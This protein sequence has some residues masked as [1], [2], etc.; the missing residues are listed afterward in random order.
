MIGELVDMD[1]VNTPTYD[2]ANAIAISCRM[3]ARMNGRKEILVPK[4][5]S[6]ARLAVVENYC[7]PEIK[8]VQ[9]AFDPKT[10]LLDLADLRKDF[11][12]DF[13]CLF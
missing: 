10:G 6:P 11:C 2:W 8:V 5:M 9:V 12:R 4:S 13:R 1:V 7:K 3:A